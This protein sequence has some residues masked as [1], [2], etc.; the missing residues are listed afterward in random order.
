MTPAERQDSKI[1]KGMSEQ[2]I[3]NSPRAKAQSKMFNSPEHEETYRSL[4]P[5]NRV[6]FDS[7]SKGD[8]KRVINSY[9]NGEDPQRVMMKMLQQD[10][11][12]YNKERDGSEDWETQMNR[13]SPASRAMQSPNR[14]EEAGPESQIFEPGME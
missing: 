3:L 14:R 2:D 11:R 8:Q 13:D 9:L 12:T 7:L 4:S 1:Q 5:K 6:V 10:Q